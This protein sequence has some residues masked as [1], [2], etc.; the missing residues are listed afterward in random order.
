M[1]N[2][3]GFDLVIIVDQSASMTGVHG[4]GS[5][6]LGVRNDM[7]KRTFELLI[8][9]GVLNNV[10]HRFGVISFGNDVR[11]DLPLIQITPDS[12]AKL[13][14]MLEASLSNQ[15]MG[16]THFLAA[17]EAAKKMFI[18][19]PV[20]EPGKRVIVFIT[21]GAADIDRIKLS[22]YMMRL[23]K[24]VESSFPYPEFQIHVVALS[25]P[26]SDYWKTDGT[27]WKKLS[28]N[29][30]IKLKE[31]REEIFRALNKVINDI[32]GTPAGHIPPNMYDNVVIPPYLE[33]LVFE[34]FRSNPEVE[35]SVFPEGNREYRSME[36]ESITFSTIGKNI[37]TI[38]IKNPK[39]GKWK[40]SK[41]D[42]NAVVHI[43]AQRFFP[44]GRLL[45]PKPDE[46]IKQFE[47]IVVKYRVEDYDQNPIEKLPGYP[48]SLELSLVKPDGSR[49][50]MEMQKS[51]DATEKSVFITTGEIE[52]DLPGTYKT[53]VI[54]FTKDL[55][56]RQVKLF[57]DQW[58]KFEV[59]KANLI[60]GILISPKPFENIPPFETLI[61]N[62]KPLVFKFKFV[63]EEGEA[64][65]LPVFLESSYKNIL[66]V[67]AVKGNKEKS[68]HMTFSFSNGLLI[69]KLQGL[70]S[71]GKHHLK[72]RP[73]NDVVPP[74]YTVR[75]SPA[76]F[77][78][79]RSLTFSH[80]LQIIGLAVLLL[81]VVIFLVHKL[82]P[83]LQFPLKGRLKAKKKVRPKIPP[84]KSPIESKKPVTQVFIS[85]SH[86]N[87]KFVNRL[88][89][90]LEKTGTSVW[91]DEKKIKV[92][93]L[94]SKKIEDGISK[95]D[96]FCLVISKHSVNSKWVERE[97]RTAL[98]MQLSPGTTPKILPL[99]IEDVELPLLLREI[100][101]ADFS[102]SYKNGYNDLLNAIKK[103]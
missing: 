15:S 88:T 85:Y 55:K 78:F 37:L 24:L 5:D 81:L 39:P 9:D 97:Y 103:Q 92:G 101:Y 11:I 70:K 94:I 84:P 7:V 71:L 60:Q 10:T 33:S 90:D 40:I 32:I 68:V 65:N 14:R 53:E 8:T 46:A 69:C 20:A 47:K 29:N 21:D 56:N 95:C 75:M 13:R 42:K 38:N 99:L 34:I 83:G 25:N 96:F 67:Y 45:F 23:R 93:D 18:T 19:G 36:L 4:A 43:F 16:G 61:F 86:K 50:V 82:F 1:T 59:K 63:D 27:F 64:L 66:N 91:L 57:R 28:H 35:V 6:W 3:R 98:N 41:S 62:T 51:S 77:Y 12:V 73:N 72:F 54:I 100:K 87:K 31:D 26:K 17:F 58:S 80:W 89:I 48:L 74:N 79:E 22:S 30:T 2:K 44:R 76:D 52:C 49:V 102:R